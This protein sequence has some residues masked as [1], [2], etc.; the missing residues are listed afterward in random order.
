MIYVALTL[1]ASAALG[2]IGRFAFR[3]RMRL[4]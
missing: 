3:A 4:A 1:I 2:L